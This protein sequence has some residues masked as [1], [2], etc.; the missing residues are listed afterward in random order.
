[1]KK[2]RWSLFVTL[3]ALLPACA[4]NTGPEAQSSAACAEKVSVPAPV[5]TCSE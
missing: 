1:M 5:T 2:I 4:K 3:L